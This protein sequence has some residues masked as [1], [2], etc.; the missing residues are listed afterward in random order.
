MITL[1]GNKKILYGLVIATILLFEISGGS[2][3]PV[4]GEATVAQETPPLNADILEAIEE[5]G[6]AKVIVALRPSTAA[7]TLQAQVQ[8]LGRTQMQVLSSLLDKDFQLLHRYWTIAGF[9][10]VVTEE[11]LERLQNNPQVL[12]I[13]LDMPVYPEL[14]E[15]TQVIRAAEAR[16]TFGVN[17]AGVTIAVLDSGVDS[18]HPDLARRIIAQ[19]CFTHSACAPNGT[20]EGESAQDVHGHGTRVTG[21]LASQGSISPQG[22]A[23][24]AA[25]VAVRV[26]DDLGQGWTSDVIAAIDWVIANQSKLGVK[27]M[28][29]SLGGGRYTGICDDQ[30]AIT[31]VYAEAIQRARDAGITVF[32]AAGNQAE[33][34]ALVVPAC[35]SGAIAVGGTYD[36]DIG[37]RNWGSCVDTKTAADKVACFS[38]SSEALDLLAPGADIRTTAIGGLVTN[39]A[40]TSMATP[41]AAAVAA[42]MLHE[43]PGLTP[44]EIERILKETGVSV[45]DPRTARVTPR[46][47]AYAALKAIAAPTQTTLSGAVYLQGRTNHSQTTLWLSEAACP[48]TAAPPT[49]ALTVTT[50]S[51]GTFTFTLTPGSTYRCLYVQHPQY[52]PAQHA[53]PASDLGAVTLPA[54]DVIADNVINI[55]DLTRVASRYNTSEAIADVNHDGTVN[56]FDLTLVAG[57]YGKRGPITEWK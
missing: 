12:A 34:N 36:A 46:I 28:N 1:T 33:T 10:G 26:M 44:D 23:P 6:V 16:S 52:L 42:L 2:V 3:T 4:L 20:N 43:D 38:N 30:D 15:S 5:T 11:G 21:I 55:F 40:G 50:G 14:A 32:A 39:D 41:H 7:N 53:L 17:G 25:I 48:S 45:T 24:G 9:S 22:I 18:S 51:Q 31:L 54:G 47:D 8:Q 29:L 56:I 37:T 27:V 19:H 35:V 49:A 57:N 13:S